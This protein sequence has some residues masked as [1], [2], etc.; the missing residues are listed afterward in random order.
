VDGRVYTLNSLS[1]L[2]CFEDEKGHIVWETDV[3][4]Q[5]EW[6]ERSITGGLAYSNGM[7]FATNGSDELVAVHA[8][9]GN[10]VWRTQIAAPSQSPP[11]VLNGRIFVTTIDNRLLALSEKDGSLLWEYVSTAEGTGVLGTASPA[12]N[13]EIVVPVF[14]NGEVVALRVENGSVAWGDTLGSSNRFSGFSTISDIEA[15]PVLDKGLL[16]SINFAGEL[17]ALDARTGQRVWMRNIG[18]FNTPWV[19][20]DVI[21]VV[22]RDNE[23]FAL[24]RNNGRIYWVTE[25]R[26]YE[27]PLDRD[28]PIYWMGPVLA[29]GR[30]FLN[31]SDGH[32]IEVDPVSGDQT[33][34]WNSFVNSGFV[35]PP[36]VAD[37]KLYFVDGNGSLYAYE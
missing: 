25:L 7:I 30:L 22:S 15:M 34:V 17:S 36:M 24:N 28:D 20:G 6:D 1:V 21:Y 14:S 16:I 37:G 11:S 13:R 12:V 18:G 4:N 26:G 8:R 9:S 29:G 35:V 32:M 3:R 2:R 23:L 33:Q 5:D 10:I 19:A 31:S 27:D